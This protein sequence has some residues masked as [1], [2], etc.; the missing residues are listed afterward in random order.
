MSVISCVS[1]RL[2]LELIEHIY[3]PT[4]VPRSLPRRLLL[5]YMPYNLTV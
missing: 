5:L 4:K 3:T 1:G 2:A